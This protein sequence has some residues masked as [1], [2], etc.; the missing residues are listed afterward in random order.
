MW[1]LQIFVD[2]IY[3]RVSKHS[4]NLSFSSLFCAIWNACLFSAWSQIIHQIDKDVLKSSLKRADL[5]RYQPSD[6]S[7]G[8]ADV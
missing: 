5:Q 3:N 2:D 7:I 4:E 6:I 8:T 1:V